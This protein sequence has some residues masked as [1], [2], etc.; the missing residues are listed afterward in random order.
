MEEDQPAG[1]GLQDRVSGFRNR[2]AGNAFPTGKTES[3][4]PKTVEVPGLFQVE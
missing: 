2:S 1:K 4:D 3:K